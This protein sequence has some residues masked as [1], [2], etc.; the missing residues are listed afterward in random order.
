MARCHAGQALHQAGGEVM[1]S[2]EFKQLTMDLGDK[3]REEAEKDYRKQAGVRAKR[4]L[5]S[6]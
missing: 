6:S 1:S 2:D 5:C 4:C 3:L